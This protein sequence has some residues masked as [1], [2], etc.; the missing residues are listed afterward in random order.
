[1]HGLHYTGR[2]ETIPGNYQSYYN[3]IYEVIRNGANLIV[4]PEQSLDLMKIIE[5]AIESN[6]S[7]NAVIF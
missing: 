5:G 6:R 4:H 2:I 3:N 1:M 7:G